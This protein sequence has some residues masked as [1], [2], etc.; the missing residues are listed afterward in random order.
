MNQL[1]RKIPKVDEVLKAPGWAELVDTYPEI[2]AKEALRTFLDQLRSG[3]REGTVASIPPIDAIVGEVRR[4]VVRETSP[5][6]K[7]VI[8]G[9]G[10]I[11]HTNLGRSL[12][13]REAVEAITN[14]ATNYVNLEYDLGEGTRGNRYEHCT[15]V[16]KK[17]TGC[18]SALVVNNNAGAV[19]LV[20]NTLAE[21]KKVII[22]RGELV[23]IGGSFRIPDVMKKS[24]AILTEV[25]TTNRTYK[26]DYERAMGEGAGLLMKAHTSNYRIDQ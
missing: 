15:S 12:L 7:R 23:E 24:G 21:G 22:S 1:L 8:N 6:L 2:P 13:A 19:F 25:G 5:S 3:I 11:I 18:E 10:V 26:Q 9:T 4:M 14:A 16:L 17:L 20:L